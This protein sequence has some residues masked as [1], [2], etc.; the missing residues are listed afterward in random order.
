MKETTKICP[1]LL[2]DQKSLVSS[3]SLS[4]EIIIVLIE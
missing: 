1:A 3:Y 2:E 4:M